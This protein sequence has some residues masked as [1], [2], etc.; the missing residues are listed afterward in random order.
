[1]IDVNFWAGRI[2][3]NT[4]YLLGP[5]EGRGWLR[6][7]PGEVGNYAAVIFSRTHLQL[8]ELCLSAHQRE[9]LGKPRRRSGCGEEWEAL[10]FSIRV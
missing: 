5:K 9:E 6:R 10:L 7:L 3:L 4:I 1:M 2:K 8:P